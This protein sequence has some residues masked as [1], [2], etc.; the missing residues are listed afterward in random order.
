MVFRVPYFMMADSHQEL[1]RGKLN[2]LGVFDR[3]YLTA[4]PK[5]YRGFTVIAQVVAETEDGLGRHRLGLRLVRPTSQTTLEIGGDADI[6][7]G[8]SPMGLASVRFV[9]GLHNVDFY[10]YG[11]HRLQ[12]LADGNVI[13]ELPFGVDPPP[14]A[15]QPR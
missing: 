5:Q 9:A 15:S 12:L 6:A 10:E 13:A 14:A 2:I 11:R 1:D 4:V 3:I 7:M 8:G